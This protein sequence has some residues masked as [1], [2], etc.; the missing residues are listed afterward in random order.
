M[1]AVPHVARF[2]RAAAHPRAGLTL[3]ELLV[4]AVLSLVVMGAVAS[5]FGILS[6]SIRQS[7]A[8]VDLSTL[9]RSAPWQLRQDLTSL[10]CTTA[11]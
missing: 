6:R 11:P 9:M 5:L 1:I 10:T 8:T 2:G 4:A 7:Q 3:V